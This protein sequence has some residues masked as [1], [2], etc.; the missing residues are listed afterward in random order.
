MKLS[1]SI[2]KIASK[3]T[4]HQTTVNIPSNDKKN[5]LPK[6]QATSKIKSLTIRQKIGNIIRQKTPIPIQKK[7]I[8]IGFQHSWTWP[9]STPN[10][11]PPNSP[12][13]LYGTWKWKDGRWH[14][15]T[16]WPCQNFLPQHKIMGEILGAQP[17]KWNNPSETHLSNEKDPYY[18]PLY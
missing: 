13:S 9:P 6:K 7:K 3:V 1:I 12:P 10:P 8:Q 4:F 17:H 5:F 18:F 16:S 14:L 15:A 2:V 11:W